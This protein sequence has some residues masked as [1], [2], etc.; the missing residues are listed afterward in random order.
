[1][2]IDGRDVGPLYDGSAPEK[3]RMFGFN[4]VPLYIKV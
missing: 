1:M 2:E 4:F 3:V